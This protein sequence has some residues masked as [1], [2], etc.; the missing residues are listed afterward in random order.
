MFI[1]C[2]THFVIWLP[3]F[4]EAKTELVMIRQR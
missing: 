3:E 1:G 2:D 4:V